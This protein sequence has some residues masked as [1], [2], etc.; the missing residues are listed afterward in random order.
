MKL[1]KQARKK[2]KKR[3]KLGV[4]PFYFI[5]VISL[6]GL[7]MAF[8]YGTWWIYWNVISQFIENENSVGMI[9]CRICAIFL[10]LGMV[11]LSSLIQHQLIRMRAGLSIKGW[12]RRTLSALLLC[13]CVLYVPL[14]IPRFCPA[15]LLVRIIFG[16]GVYVPAVIFAS[17]AQEEAL[18]SILDVRYWHRIRYYILWNCI[19]LM[20][21][22]FAPSEFYIFGMILPLLVYSA[23]QGLIM[24][25]VLHNSQPQGH[26]YYFPPQQRA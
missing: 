1:F 25:W 21:Y 22:F 8:R 13:L 7:T 17:L 11:G 5:W 3:R 23:G 15:W 14:L 18:R 4:L 9:A 24:L 2:H 10:P 20:L 16:F 6:T 19:A 12:H 26:Y